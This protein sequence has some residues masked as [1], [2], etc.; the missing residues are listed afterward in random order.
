L[1]P[2]F[3]TLLKSSLQ[4]SQSCNEINSQKNGSMTTMDEALAF[5]DKIV[6]T[7]FLEP[8]PKD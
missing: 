3:H 8:I 2:F 6:E 4:T 1:H 5:I 7:D